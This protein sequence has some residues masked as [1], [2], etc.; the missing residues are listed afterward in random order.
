METNIEKGII[1][2]RPLR[3]WW[4]NS[5]AGEFKKACSALGINLSFSDDP[6]ENIE[7]Y[8]VSVRY[9]FSGHGYQ[10]FT[11]EALNEEEAEKV[12]LKQAGD[13]PFDFDD[14]E[15][16]DIEIDNVTKQV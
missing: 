12:A 13:Y 6:R 4:D 7:K 16:D 9:T 11:V 1:G 2:G 5:S 15:V 8:T 3:D 14:A 10:D